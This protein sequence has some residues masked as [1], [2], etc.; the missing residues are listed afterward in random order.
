[1]RRDGASVLFGPDVLRIGH[2]ECRIQLL[3][4][5]DPKRPPPAVTFEDRYTLTVGGQTLE[6]AYVQSLNPEPPVAWDVRAAVGATRPA[7][8]GGAD[9]G[10]GCGGSPRWAFRLGRCGAEGVRAGLVRASG[11]SSAL[12]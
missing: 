7:R 12:G 5:D 2:S 4:D 11:G 1:V 10:V 8:L 3:R 9:P 6:L